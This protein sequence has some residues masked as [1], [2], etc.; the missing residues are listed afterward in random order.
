M[1]FKTGDKIKYTDIFWFNNLGKI[2]GLEPNNKTFIVEWAEKDVVH[3]AGFNFTFN[4]KFFE[5]CL[6]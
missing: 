2:E 5:K 6:N 4:S 1:K 3:L